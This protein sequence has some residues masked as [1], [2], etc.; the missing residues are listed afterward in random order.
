MTVK[1]E[2][3]R[4]FL[5]KLLPNLEYTKELSISQYYC[6]ITEAKDLEI[7]KPYFTELELSVPFSFRLRYSYEL[8]PPVPV[9]WDIP[10]STYEICYKHRIENRTQFIVNDEYESYVDYETFFLLCKKFG[11]KY[12]SKT[13]KIYNYENLK[14][15]IDIFNDPIVLIIAEIEVKNLQEII[16]FPP[17]L[18]SVVLCEVTKNSAFSNYNLALNHDSSDFG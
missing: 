3:E 12:L 15:E 4:K 16:K 11:K 14:W 2:N 10:P 17:N 5:L 9:N 1:K 13:R 18:E 7:V 8:K 6:K